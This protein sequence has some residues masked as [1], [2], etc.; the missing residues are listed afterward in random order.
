MKLIKLNDRTY[1]NP[2]CVVM[3]AFNSQTLKTAVFINT[4]IAIESDKTFDETAN[5]LNDHPTII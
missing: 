3:V 5:L 4:G 1:V 2:A